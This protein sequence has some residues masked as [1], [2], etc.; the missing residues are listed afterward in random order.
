MIFIFFEIFMKLI[1]PINQCPVIGAAQRYFHISIITNNKRRKNFY[2]SN[3]TAKK[4][5]LWHH[6]N[7]KI[8]TLQVSKTRTSKTIDGDKR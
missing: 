8:V 4:R 3:I 5:Y 2:N 1:M 6:F 7:E